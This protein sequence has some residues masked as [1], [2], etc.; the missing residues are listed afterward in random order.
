[1][2]NTRCQTRFVLYLKSTNIDIFISLG[3]NLSPLLFSLFISSLGPYLNSSGLG[4]DLESQNI[5]CIL[6]ADDLVLVGRTKESLDRLMS[7]TLEYLSNH[8]LSLSAKKSKIMTFD[9]STGNTVFTGPASSSI[10]LEEVLSFKYLGIHLNI[11]PR[12]FFKDFNDNV[13][14]KAHSYLSSVLSLTKAG[15][16]RA[17]LAHTLWSC[18]ALPSILYGSE[19]VPLTKGTI[20]EIERCQSSVGKFILQ[21]PRSSANVS[22][23]IDAGL[24]PVWAI[25]AEKALLFARAIMSRPITYWPKLAMRENL[26]V[27]RE[28]PYARYLMKLKVDSNIVSLNTPKMIRK[29]VKK[30][31]VD[32]VLQLQKE[33]YL[34]TFA[35]NGPG[36]S[37]HQ[38]WFK[39]KAWVNDSGASKLM[40]QFRACNAG[41]GNRGP[42]ADGQHYKLCALCDR[43]GVKALNNEVLLLKMVI[44]L[45]LSMLYV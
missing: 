15:P 16:N 28:N 33:T 9:A 31:A 38:R 39:P 36:T 27:G 21:I 17:D 29:L 7:M 37:S 2:A 18:V 22:C 4:I 11:S 20:S 45:F 34:T 14:K 5:S 44:I 12:N 30:A 41:L 25:V 1:M 19:I 32:H 6:F 8:R 13:K 40:A 42:A 24:K 10:S 23:N 43:K 26:L 3:C 35:M